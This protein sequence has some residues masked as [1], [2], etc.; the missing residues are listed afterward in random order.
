MLRISS[1]EPI[2][3]MSQYTA[4]PKGRRREE[5]LSFYLKIGQ[6]PV[7]EKGREDRQYPSTAVQ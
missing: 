1:V 3:S 6:L 5:I 4:K 7:S 2:L